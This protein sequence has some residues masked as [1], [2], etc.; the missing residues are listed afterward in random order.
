MYLGLYLSIIK[1]IKYIDSKISIGSNLRF[2]EKFLNGLIRRNLA[3]LDLVIL[4]LFSDTP[5]IKCW[6]KCYF[7]KITYRSSSVLEHYSV[8]E[9][10]SF[11]G[12]CLSFSTLSNAKIYEVTKQTKIKLTR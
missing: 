4:G 1:N 12:S 2:I 6:G 3:V 9:N 10:I 5:L 7:K 8:E 11:S